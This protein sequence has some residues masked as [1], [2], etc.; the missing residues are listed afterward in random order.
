MGLGRYLATALLA[1]AAFLYSPSSHAEDIQ[2]KVTFKDSAAQARVTPGRTLEGRLSVSASREKNK[3]V[4]EISAKDCEIR[5]GFSEFYVSLP[6]E[7][8]ITE[9]KQT[10]KVRERTQD[11]RGYEEKWIDLTPNE[12]FK[13]SALWVADWGLGHVPIPLLSEAMGTVSDTKETRIQSWAR[14]MKKKGLF[15]EELSPHYP[16]MPTA[17]STSITRRYEMSLDLEP[18]KAPEARMQVCLQDQYE[19]T[20]T[21]NDISV[22]FDG[23]SKLDTQTPAQLPKDLEKFLLDDKEIIFEKMYGPDEI[24]KIGG[25]FQQVNGCYFLFYNYPTEP[26]DIRV[27]TLITSKKDGEVYEEK[28]W[29]AGNFE[30]TKFKDDDF[31]DWAK[32]YRDSIRKGFPIRIIRC[33]DDEFTKV[34]QRTGGAAIILDTADYTIGYIGYIPSET[35]DAWQKETEPKKREANERTAA[36]FKNKLTRLRDSLKQKS[37]IKEENVERYF[38]NL[39]KYLVPQ[40]ERTGPMEHI[41][42]H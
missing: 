33:L 23:K 15:M 10:A 2:Q 16:K 18:S 7:S 13:K 21:I 31:L 28:I 39:Q 6:G 8:D 4:L 34:K 9:L 26:V 17:H 35:L 1:G 27:E 37:E 41:H 5:T 19:R 22:K 25:A 24:K 20:V 42:I 40:P 11:G 14:Q 3:L 30:Q 29:K 12:A 38:E 32:G 36:E